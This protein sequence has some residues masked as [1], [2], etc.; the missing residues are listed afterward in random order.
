MQSYDYQEYFTIVKTGHTKKT[1][2]PQDGE[3][4]WKNGTYSTR[5]GPVRVGSR[6]VLVM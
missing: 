2:S 3:A 1:A 6:I 5:A 4:V